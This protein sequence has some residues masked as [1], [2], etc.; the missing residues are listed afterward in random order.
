MSTKAITDP[1]GKRFSA[2]MKGALADLVQERLDDG[3]HSA[4][5]VV[6][7]LLLDWAFGNLDLT[8]SIRRVREG[9]ARLNSE[10]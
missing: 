6:E 9:K 4:Q 3:G 2:R 5:A 1:Q 10:E 8:D 7:A